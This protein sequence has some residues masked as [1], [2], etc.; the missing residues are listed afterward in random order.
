MKTRKQRIAYT[1]AEELSRI[2]V[3]I[4]A[5]GFGEAVKRR[6]SRLDKIIQYFKV[7]G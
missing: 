3:L 5:C 6:V 4:S 7:N 2:A 1:L